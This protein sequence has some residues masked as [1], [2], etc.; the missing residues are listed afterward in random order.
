MRTVVKQHNTPVD[1]LSTQMAPTKT[2]IRM[3]SLYFQYSPSAIYAYTCVC[4]IY[5]IFVEQGNRIQLI[6]CMG[7]HCL[8]EFV[9]H[10]TL[11][12]DRAHIMCLKPYMN[13]N[14]CSLGHTHGPVLDGVAPM[15]YTHKSGCLP[16]QHV[17]LEN[18]IS[19]VHYFDPQE[20]KKAAE[21]NF[22]PET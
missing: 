19:I 4:T 20:L 18:F 1:N 14:C 16:S 5:A 17:G 11:K 3:N 7:G 6:F 21:A 2:D 10:I 12:G 22:E 15:Y 8:F 13:N 9:L